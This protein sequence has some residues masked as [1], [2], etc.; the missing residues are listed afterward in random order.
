MPNDNPKVDRMSVAVARML[1]ETI[2]MIIAQKKLGINKRSAVAEHVKISP[3]VLT[4]ILKSNTEISIEHLWLF[5][6]FFKKVDSRFASRFFISTLLMDN[7]IDQI[8]KDAA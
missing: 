2:D 6:K 7:N 1:E 3:N 5:W 8:F 4:N